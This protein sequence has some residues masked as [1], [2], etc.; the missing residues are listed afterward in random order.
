MSNKAY[1]MVDL[2][3]T[4]SSVYPEARGNPF[5]YD[6]SVDDERYVFGSSPREA[7]DKARERL[8][9]ERNT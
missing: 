9:R 5:S 1:W 7:L 8:N 4:G 3:D 6:D 2:D